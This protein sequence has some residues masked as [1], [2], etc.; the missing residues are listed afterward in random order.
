M[1]EPLSPDRVR[2][3]VRQ[4]LDAGGVTYG[5]HALKGLDDDKMTTVDA[6]RTL[7]GGVAEPGEYV[8]GEWRYRIRTDRLV[9]VV[10]FTSFEPLRVRAVTCFA[11]N[12]KR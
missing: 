9:V 4:A 2:V 7:R 3:L 11:T 5:D 12:K 6:Q 1:D 10:R 8:S